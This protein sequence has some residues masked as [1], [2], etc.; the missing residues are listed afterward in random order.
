MRD[1]WDAQ[2][3]LRADCIEWL[4]TDPQ[5]SAFITHR[6]IQI[7]GM[8]ID[9]DLNLE[10]AQFPFTLDSAEMRFQGRHSSASSP[11]PGALSSGNSH[12]WINADG[13]KIEGSVFLR[14]GFK[15]EGEVSFVGATIGGDLECDGAQLTNP[16]GKALLLL[17]ERRSKAL[18]F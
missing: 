7:D 13:A 4:C 1:N 8:R 15:A 3:M 18:S 2:R 6:G 14:N 17:T 11:T 16:D 10:N 9:G 5:A 12:P